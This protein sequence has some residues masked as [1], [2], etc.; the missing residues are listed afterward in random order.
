MVM[1]VAEFFVTGAFLIERNCSPGKCQKAAFRL[2]TAVPFKVDVR[3]VFANREKEQAKLWSYGAISD[4]SRIEL[5]T[6]AS[7]RLFDPGMVVPEKTA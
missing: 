4:A 7:H 3:N 2:V 6:G 1:P 5:L